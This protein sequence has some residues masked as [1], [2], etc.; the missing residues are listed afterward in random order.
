MST[1]WLFPKTPDHEN[2]ELLGRLVKN[3][4][5]VVFLQNG[6]YNLMQGRINIDAACFVLKADVEAR[7]VATDVSK[8][9]YPGLVDLVFSH[10]RSVTL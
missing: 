6:V 2:A 9:D 1:L 3:G 5:T 10:Q 8:I 4:D 7:G